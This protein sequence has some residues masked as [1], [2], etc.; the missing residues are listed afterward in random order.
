MLLNVGLFFSPTLKATADFNENFDEG[1]ISGDFNEVFSSYWLDVTGDASYGYFTQENN[2][3]APWCFNIEN[4]ASIWSTFTYKYDTDTYMT[5]NDFFLRTTSGTNVQMNFYNSSDTMILQICY[6][7]DPPNTRMQFTPYG[8]GSTTIAIVAHSTYYRI[9]WSVYNNT[10]LIYYVYNIDG[11]LRGSVIGTTLSG[12]GINSTGNRITYMQVNN[13]YSATERDAYI[14][15]VSMYISGQGAYPDVTQWRHIGDWS[16]Y[17]YSGYSTAPY[18]EI[19]P[20]I[21]L[22]KVIIKGFDIVVSVDQ[23]TYASAFS[24]YHLKINGVD[25][26]SP[27]YWIPVGG[28]PYTAYILRWYGLSHSIS[29]RPL[30]ELFHTETWSVYN[31]VW[32]F[33][34]AC[35][36]GDVDGD[37]REENRWHGTPALWDGHY[38]GVIENCDLA[39]TFYYTI[40]IV[41]PDLPD[42]IG[43]NKGTH[44]VHSNVFITATASNIVYTNYITIY[45]E[46]LGYLS[47]LTQVMD[48]YT[49]YGSF[50]PWVNGSYTVNLFRDGVNVS[51]F[52][53]TVVNRT[54]ND[55]Y[56]YT[57]PNPSEASESFTVYYKYFHGE[58]KTA[59][60]VMST[61][62]SLYDENSYVEVWYPTVNATSSY[63]VNYDGSEETLYFILAVEVANE[64][65]S[66]IF[67]YPHFISGSIY[68]DYIEVTYPII[69]KDV[70]IHGS[71]IN[72]QELTYMH[73]FYGQPV[74]IRVNGDTLKSVSKN[75][76]G[77]FWFPLGLT[78]AYNVTLELETANGTI[79]LSYDTFDFLGEGEAPPDDEYIFGLPSDYMNAMFGAFITLG[80]LLLP[81]VISM[82]SKGDTSGVVYAI[83]GGIGLGV[84][85][86]AGFFPLWL[87]LMI[88]ILV[89]TI[90][91]I[92]YK[93]G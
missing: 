66:P 81:L 93:K 62:A 74:F 8:G 28:I 56:V 12:T 22:S 23:Y 3:T 79:V 21:A 85:T 18:Q 19:S 20:V 40:P 13:D 2:Y 25:V 86:I 82:K 60:L 80:F 17:S 71:T 44:E 27:N 90:L 76:Y 35:T 65:Y 4:T 77:G 55:F 78:G 39:Y 53:F 92:E 69:Y 91:V 38:N 73:T 51:S 5:G 6:N 11:S 59:K 30:F 37:G 10:H 33:M 50:V 7:Y 14:D 87:P 31:K 9:G 1:G 54:E 15:N 49:Y 46:T 43:V 36:N 45:H 63:T 52:D 84:A 16:D 70:P 47:N 41:D 26:G 61:S 75:Q 58:G 24:N 48:G 57:L 42:F 89:V 34:G 32:T 68:S 72:S 67:L 29:G 83:F 64:T 88:T